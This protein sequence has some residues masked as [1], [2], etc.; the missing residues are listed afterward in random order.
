MA[1]GSDAVSDDVELID[2]FPM[3]GLVTLLVTLYAWGAAQ[4]TFAILA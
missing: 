4:T 1:E 2:L 3:H